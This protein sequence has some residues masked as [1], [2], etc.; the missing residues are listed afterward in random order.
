VTTKSTSRSRTE[1]SAG[2]VVYHVD[3]EEAER[4]Y[5]LLRHRDGGHWAL[6]K[7][8]IEPGESERAA[9]RR[10]IGEETGIGQLR[11]HDR[12]RTEI[13][14]G[15]RRGAEQVEKTVV[16]F[17]AESEGADVA[18]SSEHTEFAW[19]GAEE[20]EA[21]MTYPEGRRVLRQAEEYLSRE[22]SG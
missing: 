2:S 12:F 10:E 17:L 4:R 18:L 20:A 1:R 6:P 16:Y 22:E 3:R 9:A 11:V 21:R 7:G 5:L 15:F 19:L 14:Y 13:H 8:R